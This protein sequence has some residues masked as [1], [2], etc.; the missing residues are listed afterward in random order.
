[1][2]EVIEIK[3]DGKDVSEIE[4]DLVELTV[5]DSLTLPNMFSIHLQDAMDLKTGKLKYTDDACPIGKSVEITIETDEILDEPGVV[6]ETIIK[7]EITGVE[8]RFT[9]SGTPSATS[10]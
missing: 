7:G 5:D 2:P 4:P 6:K 3:I 9:A 10:P 1:M 8:P